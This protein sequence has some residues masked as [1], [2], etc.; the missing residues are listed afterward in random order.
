MYFYTTRTYIKAQSYYDRIRFEPELYRIIRSGEGRV[1]PPLY[2]PR[3]ITDDFIGDVLDQPRLQAF[4]HHVQNVLLQKRSATEIASVLECCPNVHNL[5]LWIIQ[6]TCSHLIPILEKMPLRKFSFDPSYFFE[7]YAADLSIPFNQPIFLNLTHLE[8][9]NATSSWSKWKQLALL[10]KLTHLAVAGMVNQQLIDHVLE[11][12]TALELFIMFYLTM[13]FLVGEL[14]FPQK[15]D[16]V[17]LLKSVEDHLDHWEKGARGEED[18]WITGQIQ[19]ERAVLARR[20]REVQGDELKEG[21]SSE[22]NTAAV[23]V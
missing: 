12:C 4:G 16:R 19:K 14:T 5:A 2:I 3:P 20:R 22:S 7:N 13:G 6:G 17:V 1:N 11:G 9:I 23:V 18:F 15:D 10:P 21:G 8:I